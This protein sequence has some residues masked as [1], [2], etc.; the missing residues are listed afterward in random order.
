MLN[1]QFDKLTNAQELE[2]RISFFVQYKIG[3][4]DDIIFTRSGTEG[5]SDTLAL[6]AGHAIK[7]VGN[8]LSFL[9]TRT[10]VNIKESATK[11]LL[12]Y[13][14]TLHAYKSTV[15][16]NARDIDGE[17]FD[18]YEL[19]VV[20]YAVMVKRINAI[21]AMHRVISN[22]SGIYKSDV[23]MKTDIWYTPECRVAIQKM[24]DIGISAD[25]VVNSVD[26]GPTKYELA[27]IRQ[28][29]ALHKYTVK[30]IMEIIGKFNEVTQYLS[31]SYIENMM[32]KFNTCTTLLETYEAETDTNVELSEEDISAREH[33]AKIRA[34]RVWWLSHFLTSVY[35]VSTDVMRDIE[36][37]V[38][39]TTRC[40]VK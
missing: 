16:R 36:K 12:S 17:K 38:G 13:K 21:I 26:A 11:R 5:F 23:D 25:E 19:K 1:L 37:I 15:W 35:R 40:V 8:G 4:Y 27:A 34:A 29:M 9:I 2:D 10:F 3:R 32:K 31:S 18:E 22:V 20:P 28:P 14:D 24:N 39:A 30:N 33:E 7:Y 6:L